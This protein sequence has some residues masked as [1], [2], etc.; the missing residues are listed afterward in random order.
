[1]QTIYEVTVLELNF[2]MEGSSKFIGKQ[3]KE[4][5]K[6]GGKKSGKFSVDNVSQL[7]SLPGTKVVKRAK[8]SKKR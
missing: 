3:N 7:K 1:M 2:L 4:M 5:K 8:G 6:Q